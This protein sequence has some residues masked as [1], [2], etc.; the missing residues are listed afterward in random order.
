[1]TMAS[2][3]IGI[4]RRF[5][6]RKDAAEYLGISMSAMQRLCFNRKVRYYKPDGK[7]SY[8]DVADL[9]AYIMGGE[10]IEIC[11]NPERKGAFGRKKEV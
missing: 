4:Q 1:M 7:N 2:N 5:L 3:I 6:S 9:D 10:V 11:D 8:F